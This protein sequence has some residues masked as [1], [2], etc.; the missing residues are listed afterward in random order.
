MSSCLKD[1][2]RDRLL[3]SGAS[4][5]G[6]AKAEPVE[7]EFFLKF[8]RWLAEGKAG[9]L[10]YMHRHKELRKNP[11]LLLDGAQT[12][13]SV[14]WNYLPSEVRTSE[15]PHVARYAYGRDYHKALRSILRPICRDIEAKFDL[16]WRICIDSAPV[17]ERY[18]AV[19]SGIGF[20]GRNGCLIVPGVG[21][22][23][24]LSEILLTAE[25]EPDMPEKRGCMDCGVCLKECPVNALEGSG[26]LSARRCISAVTVEDTVPET[27]YQGKPHLLGCDL[28]QEK[29]PHN[30][31]ARPSVWLRPINNILSPDLGGLE[32]M[33]DETF[34]K[35]FSGTAFMR[36]GKERLLK[37]LKFKS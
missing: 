32:Q 12:V 26:L 17:A 16:K 24:F 25:V 10:D 3:K 34:R 13:V 1:Y 27:A 19:K 15:M 18:W 9:D 4:A 6:F 20:V 8:E 11:A 36:P 23:V 29:C 35:Q 5:V 33:D 31:D 30:R 21:S 2:L 37:N 28:C 22:W 14:A 7:E